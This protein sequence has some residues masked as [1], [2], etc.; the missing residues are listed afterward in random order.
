MALVFVL[1]LVTALAAL[2]VPL[3]RSSG[4]EARLAQL[5]VDSVR[6]EAAIDAV[7]LLAAAAVADGRLLPGHRQQFRF[8]G[9]PVE[10]ALSGES[11][12]V[13]LTAA[14]ADTLD[15]WL[16]AHDISGDQRVRLR[17]TLLDWRDRNPLRRPAGAEADDYRRL[18][19]L[20]PADR[21]FLHPFELAAVPGF[22]PP[23]LFQL[24]PEATVWTGRPEVEPTLAPPALRRRLDVPSGSAHRAQE[25]GQG[26]GETTAGASASA[27]GAADPAGLYRLDIRTGRAESARRVIVVLDIPPVRPVAPVLLDR[28]FWMDLPEPSS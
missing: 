1:W 24:L 15:L 9:I 10:V 2:A 5:A 17:D 16:A 3:V 20:G 4:E 12:R 22:E 6:L 8:E 26:A 7:I 13:D 19:R 14:T 18:G 27:A 21:G 28:Q 11:G 25:R 23:L